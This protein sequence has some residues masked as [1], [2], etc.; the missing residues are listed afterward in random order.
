MTNLN[1]LIARLEKATGPDRELDGD[2]A[3]YLGLPPKEMQRDTHRRWLWYAQVSPEDFDSWEAPPL[4]ESIDAAMTLVPDNRWLQLL[5]EIRS[6]IRRYGDKHTPTGF[7][8]AGLQHVDGGRLEEG[9][10]AS[11]A[12]AL[13]IASLKALAS[14][15]SGVE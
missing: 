6:E 12:I 9:C 4:T 15:R 14:I 13:C 1:D 11:P 5:K 3:V 10:G 8:L 7:W 2:I